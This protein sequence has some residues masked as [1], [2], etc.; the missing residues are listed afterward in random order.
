MTI[1]L[2]RLGITLF[3]IFSA[4]AVLAQGLSVAT[5]TR[6]PFSQVENG[7]DT[8]FA[9]ELWDLIATELN[10]SYTI[11]RLDSFQAMLSAVETGSADIAAANISITA[12]REARFDFSQPIFSSGLRIMI[13]AGQGGGS[14]LLAAIWNRDF[15]FASLAAFALLFGG[16]LLMW[17]LERN[18]QPY[19]QGTA[20][21][22]VFPAFWWALNLVVNGGFEER[23]PQT[24]LG[25]L[26]ATL[27]VI[28]SLFIVSIFVANITAAMTVKAIQSSVQSVNDLYDKRVGTTSGSTAA[29]FLDNRDIRN[30]GFASLDDLIDA[31]EAGDIDAVVFDA[32]ILSY[33]VNTRGKGIGE[34]IGPVFL[35]ESY[36]LALPADSELR[37]PINRLLL[38]FRED[39]TYDELYT[40][41][42]GADVVR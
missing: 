16:G 23:V 26:F 30:Q 13:G 39:G 31:F 21:E 5:V 22:K 9:I 14:S 34:L 29:A 33:Y 41:W 20:R 6:T 19:F 42:F 37:E 8:G 32:P 38:R 18:G 3:F 7:Q 15:L 11:Q 24:A 10:R 12:D 28:S 4:G 27:L 36:G 40:K 25:R 17:R 1:W 2:K 35:R